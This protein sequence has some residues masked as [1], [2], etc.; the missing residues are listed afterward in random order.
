MDELHEARLCVSSSPVFPTPNG[1]LGYMVITP[2][3]A[4]KRVN[5]YVVGLPGKSTLWGDR[6]QISQW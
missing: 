5:D 3:V 6:R 2:Y 1:D 4:V